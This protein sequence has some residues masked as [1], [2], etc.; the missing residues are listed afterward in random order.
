MKIE[1]LSLLHFC[2]SVP[3][4]IISIVM[5]EYSSQSAIRCICSSRVKWIVEINKKYCAIYRWVVYWTY[6]SVGDVLCF[7]WWKHFNITNPKKYN[8]SEIYC[9]C[10]K[11][12]EVGLIWK[13][14]RIYFIPTITSGFWFLGVILLVTMNGAIVLIMHRKVKMQDVFQRSALDSWRIHGSIFWC[15]RSRGATPI[16]PALTLLC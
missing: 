15:P 13:H 1:P 12:Y 10:R 9:L 6:L 14:W 16:H 7:R 11:W 2:T 4:P 8:L 3:S 5:K